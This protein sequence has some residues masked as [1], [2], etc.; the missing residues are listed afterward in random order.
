MSSTTTNIVAY[1]RD[2][3]AAN[4]PLISRGELRI[5][6]MAYWP[7][8]PDGYCL[9]IFHKERDTNLQTINRYNI[10]TGDMQHVT[11]LEP[12]GGGAPEGAFITNEFD[13]YSWVLMTVSNQ[14][15]VSGGDRVDVW[16]LDAR[17]DW[18]G[19]DTM[20]GTLQQGEQQDFVLTLDAS[21]MPAVEFDAELVFY[22]NAL[23]GRWILPV[24]LNVIGGIRGIDL[25]LHPGWNLVS[26][27]VEPDDLDEQEIV[28]PLVEQNELIIMK[29]GVGQ[30]YMP[31]LGFSNIDNWRVSEGYQLYMTDEAVLSVRGRAVASDE[32][33][34][35]VEGWN[36][37]SYYPTVPVDAVVA[38][39]GIKEALDV[40]KNIDGRF[41]MPEFDFTNMGDMR[42]GQG[43]QI[44]VH[45]E[46][47]L[48]YQVP[49][50]R[51]LAHQQ[52]SWRAP[53]HFK[54]GLKTSDNMSVLVL[55]NPSLAD[56]EIC[57]YTKAGRP[58]GSG[59]IDW[60][61]RC[62]FAV[63]GDEMLTPADDGAIDREELNFQLWNGEA[64]MVVQLELLVGSNRWEADGWMVGRLHGDG[65][66]PVA[67]GIFSS[68]PNPT[69]GPARLSFGLENEGMAA[70]KVYDISGRLVQTLV[71][72]PLSVGYHQTVW[73]TDLISSGVYLI[74]LEAAGR[75]SS[76]K[77]AVVK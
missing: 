36:M 56:G 35:L 62:G 76:I 6:G 45:Q 47:D 7:D 59:V 5:Y 3:H 48:V 42:E 54:P 22:H 27:N 60:Q 71:N 44:R 63:W 72:G 29:N 38:L 12:Q 41:Y 10:E 49:Q 64:E 55:T 24:T 77:V 16:Q 65:S 15:P 51:Q 69:N 26:I 39:D 2:G 61:G 57:A 23:N 4:L 8:D 52:S 19:L 30:F 28:N 11:Y 13:I 43:Y 40:V 50:R 70:L 46:V 25:Q 53:Q 18:F 67:F 58:V 32:P 73:N 74:R 9:Y 14:P 66:T 21:N 31:E 75:A 37:A 1:T 68:W 17:R 33:I 34:P 20:T